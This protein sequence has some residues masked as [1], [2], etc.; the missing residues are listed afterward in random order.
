MK[1]AGV[2]ETDVINTLTNEATRISRFIR[3]KLQLIE[4]IQKEENEINPTV[5]FH[6][7]GKNFILL[8][9][10]EYILLSKK[11]DALLIYLKNIKIPNAK[12]YANT[13]N[14]IYKQLD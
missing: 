4:N 1:I 6:G 13:L 7:Y 3:L 9:A 2:S 5:E 11:E 12:K 14:R 8:Y 10:L